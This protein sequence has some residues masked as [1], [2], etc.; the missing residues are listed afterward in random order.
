MVGE[1]V[2]RRSGTRW[3]LYDGQ[4]KVPVVNRRGPRRERPSVPAGESDRLS[5]IC[6]YISIARGT[7]RRY[8][9][10]E[11]KRVANLEKHGLDFRYAWEIFE[12]A[13]IDTKS[14]L[15]SV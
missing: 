1:I 15:P 8:N 13:H 3:T 14:E 7:V 10:H 4:G 12:G 5:Y 11:P 6:T 2:E 9:W